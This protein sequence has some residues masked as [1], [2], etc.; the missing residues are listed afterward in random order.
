MKTEEAITSRRSVKY[1]D[2]DHQMSD[3]EIKKL[4]KSR[5]QS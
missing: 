4:Q 2:P 1:F 3:D 5:R